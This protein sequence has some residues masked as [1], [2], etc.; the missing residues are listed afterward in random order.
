MAERRSLIPGIPGIAPTKK[1]VPASAVNIRIRRTTPSAI[2]AWGWY[3]DGKRV[4]GHDLAY[5]TRHAKAGEG[6]VWLGLHD[7]TD[8]D[9]ADFARQFDLHPLAIEDAVEGH[10]RSKVEQFD[11]TLFAVVSTVKYVDHRS[12]TEV[13][14][15]V[16]TGQIMVFSGPGFVLTV[17]RG[18]HSGLSGMRTELEQDPE[19]L[20]TGPISV[21]YGVLDKVIDDYNLV[22][23]EFENDIDEVENDIFGRKTSTAD[24]DRV[25]QL[26]RELIEFRRAVAPLGS[27]LSAL[28]NR[29]FK[30][31]PEDFR[32]YFRELSDHLVEARESI[33]SFSDALDAIQ[34]AG[35]A[36]ISVTDNQDMRKI[37]AAVAILAVPTTI[38]GWYGMNFEHMPEL[39]MQYAYYVVLSITGAIMVGLFLLFKRNKWL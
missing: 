39:R 31:V 17:R 33:Q 11:E 16:S 23:E 27:P 13:A 15:I 37:S 35:V 5:A 20:A 38:F 18:E 10:T 12:L 32:H 28:A 30:M 36:R 6:F 24:V 2:V 34:Q 1:P 29:P 26:K 22:V 9:M 25:Y 19:F 4:T 21:L 14:E 8:E 3:V 7:P